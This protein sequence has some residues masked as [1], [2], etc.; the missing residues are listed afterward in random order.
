MRVNVKNLDKNKT[1]CQN[2]I[3]GQ[4]L[5]AEQKITQSGKSKKK[6]KR[7]PRN[8]KKCN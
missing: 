5:K 8:L 4:G 7:S 2:F 3:I 1:S 6:I